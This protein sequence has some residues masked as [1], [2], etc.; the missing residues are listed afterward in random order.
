MDEERAYPRLLRQP[1]AAKWGGSTLTSTAF[2]AANCSR[3]SCSLAPRT[4]AVMMNNPFIRVSLHSLVALLRSDRLLS[5]FS[6]SSMPVIC[7][8][9]F[10]AEGCQASLPLAFLALLTFSVALHGSHL[11]YMKINNSI[12]E[13]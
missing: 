4:N 2:T 5:E 13:L 7:G 1:A 6:G 9:D 11:A 10:N 12:I 3:K 8:F